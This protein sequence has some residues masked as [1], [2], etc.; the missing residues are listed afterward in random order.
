MAPGL[1]AGSPPRRPGVGG[2]LSLRLERVGRPSEARARARRM[3]LRAQRRLSAP[4]A[5][6]EIS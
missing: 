4:L 2:T 5:I 3:R 6:S 1:V